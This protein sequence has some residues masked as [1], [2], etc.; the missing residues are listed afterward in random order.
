MSEIGKRLDAIVDVRLRHLLKAAGYAKSGRTWRKRV[1]DGVLV[2]NIQGDKW[3]W[4]GVGRFT[5]NL[6]VSLPAVHQ[7]LF[8]FP[9]PP[10]PAEYQCE[11]RAR[12][13]EGT[14]IYHEW[15]TVK[16]STDTEA[17]GIE[18]GR[19]WSDQA[20]PWLEARST[21]KDAAQAVWDD[22]GNSNATYWP[23]FAL[24]LLVGRHQDAQQYFRNMLL[25]H[26]RRLRPSMRRLAEKLWNRLPEEEKR[27][28]ALPLSSYTRDARNELHRLEQLADLMDS[29]FRVPGTQIRIGLDAIIGLIP[30]I[31]DCATLAISGYI[32]SR[33][34]HLDV[35]YRVLLRMIGNMLCDWLM[36]IVPGI[37]DVID[38]GFRANLRNVDLIRKHLS[39]DSPT[40]TTG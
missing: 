16:E 29:R 28:T 37:G 19:A 26:P 15:W 27:G 38:I 13:G 2:F 24:L 10:K 33:A 18:W 11:L 31:G 5:M 35:P 4:G 25:V 30:G 22:T 21:L 7:L 40:D 12:I 9:A 1:S 36:G 20:L 23:D 14:G 3:N 8:D 17:L 6:G 32:V 39:P 34:F